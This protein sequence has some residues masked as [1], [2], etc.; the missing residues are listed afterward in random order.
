MLPKRLLPIIAPLLM[1]VFMVT[2]MT[3]VIT[4]VNTGID[5]GFLLRWGGAFIVAWP[6]AFSFIFLFSKRIYALAQSICSV[7]S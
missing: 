1:S 5:D 3:A 2:L 7:E 4:A 6:I